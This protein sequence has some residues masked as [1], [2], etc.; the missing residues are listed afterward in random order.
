MRRRHVNH[1][2]IGPNEKS[3]DLST[4]K[5][6]DLRLENI[7]AWQLFLRTLNANLYL[8]GLL[9]QP[10]ALIRGLPQGSVLGPRCFVPLS[11]A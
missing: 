7:M 10:F 3:H 11:V 6:F 5:K 4:A 8:I 1:A 2:M 9:S